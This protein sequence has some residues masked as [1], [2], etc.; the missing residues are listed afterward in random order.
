ME[1]DY[2]I[3]ITHAL[4]RGTSEETVVANLRAEL[5]KTG[6]LKLLPG[7]L[8][9]LEALEARSATLTSVVEVARE[10]DS[11]QALEEARS[12]GIDAHKAT[13]NPSLIS[14]WRAR[15]GSTLI[16]RSGKHALVDLYHRITT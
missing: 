11:K 7:I 4:A 15:S 12:A 5:T 10:E 6:R 8:R 1:R 16:D 13:V 3:A 14:G 9:E 2:A